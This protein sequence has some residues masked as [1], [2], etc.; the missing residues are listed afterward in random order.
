MQD[1]AKNLKK[2][3]TQPRGKSIYRFSA[4]N[5]KAGKITFFPALSAIKKANTVRFF[6]CN[7]P[8]LSLSA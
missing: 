1:S 7:Q 6:Y 3:S 8:P 5:H 4:D 2:H